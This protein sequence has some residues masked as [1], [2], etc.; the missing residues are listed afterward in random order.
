MQKR[1]QASPDDGDAMVLTFAA[2]VM[3]PDPWRR[4]RAVRPPYLSSPQS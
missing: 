3:P 4:A 1:E 2:P